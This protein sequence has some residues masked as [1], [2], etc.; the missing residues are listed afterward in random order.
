M[1]VN[2]NNFLSVLYITIFFVVLY[3]VITLLPS[4]KCGF[5]HYE[6]IVNENGESEFC[7]TNNSSFLDLS[8]LKY[9]VEMEIDWNHES[10]SGKLILKTKGG[11]KLL[12]HELA[13]THTEKMHLLLIDDSLN[14]YHHI[15]P[16]EDFNDYFFSFNPNNMTNYKAFLEVVPIKTRRQLIATDSIKV[17]NEKINKNFSRSSLFSINNVN[18]ELLDVPS[19]INKNRDYLF[20]LKVTDLVG[21]NI[22]LDDIMGAKA[23][24]VAFDENQKGFLHMHPMNSI[25]QNTND[26]KMK[27]LFNV[28]NIGWYRLFAQV[29]IDGSQIYASFDLFVD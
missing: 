8:I 9:P 7:A 4:T 15:H 13:L 17:G 18:F 27:F 25:S 26:Q 12:P 10:K 1:K 11:N 24:M 23:H 28:P 29:K 5:L 3:F 6:T 21:V 19:K 16:N 20:E 22:K 14:D 2:S